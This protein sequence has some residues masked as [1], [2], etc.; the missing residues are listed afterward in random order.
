VK[1]AEGF[2]KGNRRH[3]TNG[4]AHYKA[5]FKCDLILGL[6]RRVNLDRT[7]TKQQQQTF[8]HPQTSCDGRATSS[9]VFI[10]RAFC[11]PQKFPPFSL[12]FPFISWKEKGKIAAFFVVAYENLKMDEKKTSI[13]EWKC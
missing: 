10:S 4:A 8:H 1:S 5:S 13:D 11:H 3:C 7:N 2:L 9:Q 6:G 12:R